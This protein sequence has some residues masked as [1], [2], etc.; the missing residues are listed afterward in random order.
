VTGTDDFGGDAPLA[1]AA[2]TTGPDAVLRHDGVPADSE[3]RVRGPVQTTDGKGR[4]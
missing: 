3:S 4:C 2:T 1:L